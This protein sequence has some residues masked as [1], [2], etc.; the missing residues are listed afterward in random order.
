[1]R[2]TAS[3]QLAEGAPPH[4]D[5]HPMRA[6]FL[7]P[8][9]PPPKLSDSNLW[10][11]NFRDFVTKCCKKDPKERPTAREMLL[12]PFI[13]GNGKTKVVLAKMVEAAI[14]FYT[15]NGHVLV[16]LLVCCHDNRVKMSQRMRTM[17][18]ML[19]LILLE[20]LMPEPKYLPRMAHVLLRTPSG[21][22]R[23]N[24]KVTKLG[25]IFT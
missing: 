21:T 12:H 23:P 4:A 7:I 13:S 18:P 19:V 1:M 2:D 17:T 14:N 25:T 22:P 15:Q 24:Q 16:W 9:V 5:V 8:Q 11:A 3:Q 10:S 6:I 20:L